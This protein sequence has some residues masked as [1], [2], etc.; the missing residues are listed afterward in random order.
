MVSSSDQPL[1]AANALAPSEPAAIQPVVE[2]KGVRSMRHFPWVLTGLS[3]EQIEHHY[4][5]MRNSHASLS[6]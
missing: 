5:A 6:Y 1:E 3:P 2:W 4:K